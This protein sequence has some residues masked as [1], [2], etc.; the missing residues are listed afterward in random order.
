MLIG[1]SNWPATWRYTAA[2]VCAH[3]SALLKLLL[4]DGALQLDF[5]D[6]IIKSTCITHADK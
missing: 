4:K 5:T 6:E 1:L 2:D 3:I